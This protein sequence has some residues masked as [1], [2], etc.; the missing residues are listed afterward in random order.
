MDDIKTRALEAHSE[1]RSLEA[2]Q[3]YRLLLN[4]SDDP[5]IAANLGALLRSQGRLKEAGEHYHQ[6]LKRWP[7]QR[8][9]LLNACNC[10]RDTGETDSALHW[11]QKAL[12]LQPGEA[13]LLESLA[14]TQAGRGDN[15][16]AIRLFET[17]LR[18]HPQRVNSWLGLGL[19]Q[20]RSGHFS[21]S[22]ACFR[23][24]LA[25]EPR[26][27]RAA[28]NLITLFKQT[29]DF[30]SANQLIQELNREQTNNPDIRKAIADLR[31]AEGDNVGASHL[32]AKLASSHQS[33]A[34][35]WLNWAASLK[36]LKF[37]VA[38]TQILKRGLQFN[39]EDHNLWLALEQALCELCDFE[40]AERV[41]ALHKLDKNLESNEQ[42]FNRQ[43]LSLSVQQTEELCQKRKQWALHWEGCQQ[44]MGHG[45]LWPDLL[46]EPLA[47]RRLRIGYLSADFCNH[48][49]GRFLLPVL[50]HHDR[51]SMEVWGISC[52]PHR[53]W[54]SEHIQNR[55]EHWI[56]CRFH[57]DAQAARLIADLRLD[58]L[59]ELGGFTSGSR[60]G[61]LT[62]RPA[63][64][65]LSYLGFPAPVY[66][67]CIDG[68]LGDE[69][70]FGGLSPTDHEAHEQLAIDGGYMVFDPGGRLPSPVRD[71]PDRFCFGSFNHA[72]KLSDATIGLFCDVMQACPDA[73]LVLKSISFHE[74]AEQDRIRTRF[75]KAGLDPKRLRLLGWIEGGIH[76]LQLYRTMDVALDPIPYGGATTT[77]EALWMG[78]PVIALQGEG[79]VGRLS[80][81][82]LHHAGLETY[83][84][85][86]EADYIM[87]A[88]K[89]SEQGPRMAVDRSELRQ[90]V[91]QSAV[92][93][94]R[95]LSRELEGIYRGL[96]SRLTGS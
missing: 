57:S 88:K 20:G 75:E 13:D 67:N 4:K 7:N 83:V 48:P 54:I 11:L 17:I 58:V 3:S 29:G 5:D 64:I 95:R 22:S 82:L 63:P 47:S 23:K 46:L 1:G 71:A 51:Q 38:P 39:P 92:A 69:V 28:A 59:V 43:F 45:P 12:A 91:E 41:C 94:G 10:W 70:L 32:L 8:N 52:G 26:E 33:R 68:W 60:L 66:L 21:A 27:H 89:V 36:G 73:D 72:R 80:A 9:L 86:N 65:Q 96:R 81:S 25:L 90:Q 34:E 53:D 55:C 16:E 93:D 19:V 84:A 30:D 6:C 24:V 87:I 61:I 56:D 14:E 85:S 37:S 31:L 62:H 49:V 50:E 79:M 77:A 40:G 76:H 15:Q 42:I 18:D 35:I 44:R 78:V 74:Q 2:E